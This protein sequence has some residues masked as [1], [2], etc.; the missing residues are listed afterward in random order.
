VLER[1]L[2]SLHGLRF[3]YVRTDACDADVKGKMPPSPATSIAD[4]VRAPLCAPLRYS[5]VPHGTP[6]HSTVLHGTPRYPTVLHGTPRYSTVLGLALRVSNRRFCCRPS[7]C[8]TRGVATKRTQRSLAAAAIGSRACAPLRRWAATA[9]SLIERTAHTRPAAPMSTT[10]STRTRPRRGTSTSTC[11]IFRQLT[12]RS[13]ARFGRLWPAALACAL[14]VRWTCGCSATAHNRAHASASSCT[15][16]TS[17]RTTQ[18]AQAASIRACSM[19]PERGLRSLLLYIVVPLPSGPQC[20][21]EGMRLASQACGRPITAHSRHG[22]PMAGLL[23]KAQST[24]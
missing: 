22:A 15:S 5:T 24:H 7:R 10:R 17:S 18:C 1:T 13:M 12:A 9:P 8:T 21:S 16:P 3:K 23:I 11:C 14:S 6:R 20:C 19:Q 2:A 4:Y